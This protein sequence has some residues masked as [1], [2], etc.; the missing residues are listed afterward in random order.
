MPKF[1]DEEADTM[2]E[3]LKDVQEVFK[4]HFSDSDYDRSQF[5]ADVETNIHIFLYEHKQT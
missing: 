4:E 1:T 3:L 5:L 2:Y